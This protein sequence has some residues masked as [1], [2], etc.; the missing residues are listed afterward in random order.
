[1]AAGDQDALAYA[2]G[3]CLGNPGPG[4]WG[5][6]LIKPSGEEIELSGAHPATTNNRME[7]TAAIEALRAVPAGSRVT[8]RSD[9]ELL[10]KSVNLGWKRN[11][12]LDLWREL[13]AEKAVRKVSFEW[14]RGHADDLLNERADRLARG[15]A[16]RI[17]SAGKH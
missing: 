7:L 3:S 14:V 8:V 5:V 12:N 6:V 10:V 13:D 11:K 1:V 4:G 17:R 15:A 2:D 9:S 16:E